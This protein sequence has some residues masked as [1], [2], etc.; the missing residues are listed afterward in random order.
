MPRQAR[1]DAPGALHHILTR[2]I[3]QRKIFEDD[4]DREDFLERLSRL[5]QEMGTV[6]YGWALMTNHVHL[7]LR[8]GTA[9]IA[10]LMR[11]LLTGYAVRFNR[12]HRRY[13]HLFQNRYKSILCEEDSYLKQLV[14]Y[15]HLNPFRAGIVADVA[16]LKVYPFTGHS[17][18][19]GKKDRPWQDTEYV[20]TLF[21]KTVSEARQ[22][23]QRHMVKWSAKGRCPELTGGGLVRSAGG[24]R[25]VKE[26]YRDG[27]RLAG[28]ERILGSSEF[29]ETTLKRAG[30][31]YDRRTRIQSAG[32]DLSG[33]IMAVCRYF[34][35]EEKELASP[36]RRLK[37]ARARALV[38]Y[39]ATRELSI[40]GSEVARRLNVDRSA[41][42]RA[43]QRA[44][45]DANLIAAAGTI[46][47][48]L[49]SK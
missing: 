32:M 31:A 24:W 5:V 21:G 41:I 7:L 23:L 36:T 27:I 16:T 44:E 40:S 6:C 2:G 33:V 10:S 35:I 42:S 3:E 1:I 47:Q 15:I 37:I 20:L 39:I 25:A 49:D 34:K 48:P 19:M 11:R 26:A 22:N 4:K 14:A 30:E 46:L 18:L 13:G 45:N 43:V 8:T 17:A 28:D 29:V 9:P 38:G 12:R